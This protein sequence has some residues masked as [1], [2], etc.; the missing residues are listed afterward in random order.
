MRILPC[1]TAINLTACGRVCYGRRKGRAASSVG[2]QIIKREYDPDRPM[3][4]RQLLQ[5][6]RQPTSCN[7]RARAWTCR[8]HEGDS[9]DE[10]AR[11]ACERPIH[12]HDLRRRTLSAVQEPCNIPDTMTSPNPAGGTFPARPATLQFPVENC[13]GTTCG[14]DEVLR[15]NARLRDAMDAV[16]KQNHRESAASKATRK[17]SETVVF[18]SPLSHDRTL[19]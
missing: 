5:R 10:L 14:T 3:A 12:P 18:P 13:H 2:K 17:T 19:G 8:R 6:R 7:C 16:R 15:A 4:R 1:R 11:H 9:V